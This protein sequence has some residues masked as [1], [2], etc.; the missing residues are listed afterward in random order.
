MGFKEVLKAQ[1]ALL[2]VPVVVLVAS[3][4][5]V[6]VPLYVFQSGVITS[7]ARFYGSRFGYLEKIEDLQPP[8]EVAELPVEPVVYFLAWFFTILFLS[9]LASV[10][11]EG[12]LRRQLDYAIAYSGSPARA[13]LAISWSLLVL[14]V[15][16]II[17]LS[18]GF[19]IVGFTVLGW[20]YIRALGFGLHFLLSSLALA[21]SISAMI[22]YIR[23]PHRFWLV[24]VA[25]LASIYVSILIR[26]DLLR[27]I[28]PI[29]GFTDYIS[30]G[31]L[32]SLVAPIALYLTPL[33]LTYLALL[34]RR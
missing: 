19:T 12:S 1:L 10:L 26:V 33:I 18:L 24:V 16:S 7:Y 5:S 32:E 25:L 14:M 28:S 31:R 2:Q 20:G 22:S 27:V 15:P 11:S 17:V 8:R 21:L 13:L 29:A 30:T 6:L 34:Y 23:A 9:L 4:L 3:L